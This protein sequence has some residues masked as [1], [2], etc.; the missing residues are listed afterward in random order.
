MTYTDFDC[1]IEAPHRHTGEIVE[2]HFIDYWC[3]TLTAWIRNTESYGNQC[4]C[5]TRHVIAR[6]QTIIT[7]RID[8]LRLEGESLEDYYGS[9]IVQ[10][11]REELEERYNFLLFHGEEAYR[12][13][14]QKP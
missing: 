4:E 6:T 8:L 1:G 7:E 14:Y 2:G 10:Y 9:E 5:K 3:P 12:E 11:I 13:K